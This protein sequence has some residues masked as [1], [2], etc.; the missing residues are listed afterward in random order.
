M[1]VYHLVDERGIRGYDMCPL[2]IAGITKGRL[3]RLFTHVHW[4]ELRRQGLLETYSIPPLHHK[5]LIH[6]KHK[7]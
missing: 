1:T 5:N 4:S 2:V 3:L 6:C 7:L